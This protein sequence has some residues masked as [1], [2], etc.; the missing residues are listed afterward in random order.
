MAIVLTKG[1]TYN[2]EFSSPDY[3]TLTSDWT[4]S[5]T[6]YSAY[7]ST[8]VMVKTL[9]RVGNVMVLTVAGADIAALDS[10]VYDTVIAFSNAILGITI[11]SKHPTTVV[12]ALVSGSGMTTL[13][14][15]IAKID[16]TAAGKETSTLTNT[17]NGVVVTLGWDGVQVTASHPVAD[18]VSGSIIG[19]E[20][21]TTKTNAAGYAQLTVIMGQTVT[22]TCPVF[23]KSVTVNTAGLTTVDLSSYF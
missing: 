19:T 16:G 17:I 10:G 5:I 2:A 20:T 7:P 4:G 18:T 9:T 3:P 6:L 8:P 1:T 14:M 22:V 23:G 12:D 15:T 11:E 21:V 13:T